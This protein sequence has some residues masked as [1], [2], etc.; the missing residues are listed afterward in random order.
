MR[1]GLDFTFRGV[2]RYVPGVVRPP[3]L[4]AWRCVEVVSFR[5]TAVR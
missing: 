5:R 1:R 3:Q 2:L 4:V